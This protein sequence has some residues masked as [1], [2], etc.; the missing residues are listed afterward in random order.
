M[1]WG[2]RLQL[3]RGLSKLLRTPTDKLCGQRLSDWLD[4]A[5]QGERVRSGFW[6]LVLV[7]ALSETLDRIDAAYARKVLLDG[8]ARHRSGWEVLIPTVSLTELYDRY[9][10][11]WL[12]SREVLIERSSGVEAIHS[13]GQRVTRITTRPGESIEVQE[14]IAAVPP[15]RLIPLLQAG[16]LLRN[17]SQA[18]RVPSPRTRTRGERGVGRV[19]VQAGVDGDS[20]NRQCPLVV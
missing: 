16:N 5:G 2:E 7:S 11:S 3:L 18:L 20:S 9:A 1:S 10:A 19:L 8:F 15:Y 13:D 6:H 14:L 12:T 17:W 4:Q